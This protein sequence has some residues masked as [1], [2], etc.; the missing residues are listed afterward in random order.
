MMQRLVLALI[1][2]LS[3]GVTSAEEKEGGII[4]TG[5]V[6]EVTALDTFEVAGMRFNL[7]ETVVLTGIDRIEDLRMG[8]TLSLRAARDGEGWQA[9]ELR[10]LPVLIGPITGENEVMGVPVFGDLPKGGAV[11]IDGFWSTQ[12]VVATRVTPTERGVDQVIGRYDPEGS[13]GTVRLLGEHTVNAERGDVIMVTGKYQRDGFAVVDTEIGVFKGA[14]PDLLLVEGFFDEPNPAGDAI[15][16]T[17]DARMA[18][19]GGAA[20]SDQKVRRCAL[21]GRV[22]YERSTLSEGDV[23]TIDDFCISETR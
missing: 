11:V 5:V 20:G 13:V 7:P 2:F 12:G 21:H 15:L 19:N 3:F 16:L 4:G 8:M 23:K 14:V 10:H 17:I 9:T 1:L 18:L 6:G 22:D